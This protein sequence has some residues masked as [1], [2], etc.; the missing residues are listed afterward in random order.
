MRRH[1]ALA[2]GIMAGNLLEAR[3]TRPAGGSSGRRLMARIILKGAR[4]HQRSLTTGAGQ[5][6]LAA[7]EMTA[8]W[9]HW[10]LG[11]R[12]CGG[13]NLAILGGD[14]L[15]TELCVL[16]KSRGPRFVVVSAP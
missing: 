6:V 11:P 7:V 13:P 15:G 5:I 10:D 16:E 9:E 8:L 14:E 1:F 4:R 3:I 12:R 2:F